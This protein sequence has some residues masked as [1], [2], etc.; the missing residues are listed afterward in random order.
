[1]VLE[2]KKIIYLVGF[3]G[4]GKSTIGLKLSSALKY[5]FFDTDD[6]VESSSG[7]KISQIFD[8]QGEQAFR[9]L[10]SKALTAV[11]HQDYAVV[12]TGGGVVGKPEN[13]Q[14][15]NRNG[16]VVYLNANWGTIESRLL[17]TSER[18]L[19][20]NGTDAKLYQLWKHRQP[21]YLQADKVIVTD[22]L[23]PQQVVE[24]IL[25][26]LHIE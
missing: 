21:L 7:R 5:S 9:D 25:L 10:E 13:W 11:S 16:V 2:N 17:D 1:M 22:Q 20:D 26:A 24:Q 19:A 23:N 8:E 18:P 6:E 15:M 4:V 14:V 12:S 3:M